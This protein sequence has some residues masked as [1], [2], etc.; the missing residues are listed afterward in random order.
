MTYPISRRRF[1]TAAT[2]LP[3]MSPSFSALAA[4]PANPD[5]VVVGAGI[6]GITAARTL[7]QAG[8]EVAVLEARN[9]IGGRAYTESK[10][11]GVP[12][13]HGCAWL[14]SANVN[15]LTKL[16]KDAGFEIED[17]ED[18]DTWLYLDGEEATDD[19][20]ESLEDAYESLSGAID[21]AY[22]EDEQSGQD[23]SL[24]ELRPPPNR[25]DRM[26][27][28][29]FGP[30][31]AGED[32]ENLS[33]VDIF[34]Q[35]GTG[36]EWMVPDG[37]AAAIFKALGP[38][39][40][41]LSTTVKKIKWGDPEIAV[42][43]NQGTL[44]AKAV[45]I[46]V[47]TE[48]IADGTIAFEPALPDWK[49][50]AYRNVPMGVLDK[51]TTQFSRN[52]FEDAELT[53]LYE[54]TGA[55][56]HVWDHLLRPFGHNLVVTF[57]GGQFARDLTREGDEAA[58]DLALDSLTEV[59]GSDIRKTFV[60]GHF[61][62]WDADPLARGAYSFVRPNHVR[63]RGDTG[64]RQAVFRR[65]GVYHALGDPSRGGL[66]NRHGRR[67]GGSRGSEIGPAA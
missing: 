20:Y 43:T 46:T 44:R 50:D 34:S 30:L 24:T 12:Y 53:T 28:E 48:I 5:V 18:T 35:V 29:M 25:F 65:R 36:V 22:D 54:Q 13:D 41:Q 38:V 45:I 56:G 17:E 6:A 63:D 7:R 10:T 66:H 33:A 23:M 64:G 15:P 9:R 59:F 2:A 40:V 4:L 21:R 31:E 37:M 57:I 11:F 3:L 55:D 19:Q 8:V 1:L 14:H 39:P 60:K 32:P 16:V 58:F 52:V 26:A 62:K 61:T 51:I 49:L 42:E 47:P 67:Q 27:H